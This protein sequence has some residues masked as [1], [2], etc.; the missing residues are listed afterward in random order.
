[1]LRNAGEYVPCS[2]DIEGVDGAMVPPMEVLEAGTI[3]WLEYLVGFFLLN[4]NPSYRDVRDHCGQRW[5]IRDWHQVQ[6]DNS[7]FFF[8]FS[9]KEER[10]KECLRRF[11]PL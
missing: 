5:N 6:F 7:L 2:F 9:G 1:M 3:F 4:S 10:L 8:K 11:P